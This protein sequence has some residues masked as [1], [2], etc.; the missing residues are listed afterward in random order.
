MKT[1]V[2]SG[3][4]SN[5]GKTTLARNVATLLTDALLVKIGHHPAKSTKMELLYPIGTSIDELKRL[6]GDHAYL[7]IE[8][9]SILNDFTPDCTIFLSADSPKPSALA[10]KEKAD[11]IR[12]EKIDEPAVI[13]LAKR[14][15]VEP[16]LMHRMIILSG[17]K[18]RRLPPPVSYEPSA[19]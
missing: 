8:S 9:N 18:A 10:A 2:I 15:A 5:V 6:H 19:I 7:I 12:G 13:D 4:R 17:A 3:A 11:I 16:Q 14:L 1:I